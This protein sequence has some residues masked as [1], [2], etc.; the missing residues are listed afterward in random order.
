[1]L[2]PYCALGRLL[3]FQESL[4]GFVASVLQVCTGSALKVL[5]P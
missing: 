4:E 1:M 3:S 5:R 2:A